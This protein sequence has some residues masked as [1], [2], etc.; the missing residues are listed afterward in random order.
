MKSNKVTA[1]ILTHDSESTIG[2]VIRGC[3][4][5]TSRIIVVDDF[6]KDK[7]VSIA[8][9][10]KCHVVRHKFENY[11][12][13]R[14]WAQRYAKLEPDE[15]VLNIDHD[16]V[17]SPQLAQNIKKEVEKD[18]ADGLLI[19][20]RIYFMGK[21]IR[22]GYINPSWHLVAY[23]AGKGFCEERLYDQHFV[24]NG[25]EKRI[26]GLLHDFQMDSLEIWTEMHNK[27]SSLEAEE[28]LFE[29]NKVKKVL[30]GKLN[31]DKRMQKRWV[32]NNIYYRCPLLIRPLLFFIYSYIFRLGFLD[33]KAGLIFHVLQSGWFRFLV[34][35]KIV[36]MQ[37]K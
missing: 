3:R 12:Q 20:K 18:N 26:G 31:G 25:K 4:Q 35:A 24:V 2:K 36:E 19:K 8:G 15:W 33:G 29:S 9:A 23:K 1:I 11:S 5:V 17:I 34:D 7:T 16:E 14:N 10:M 21:P 22:F 13:Q 6:S 28:I 30:P 27:W 37:K 32:K